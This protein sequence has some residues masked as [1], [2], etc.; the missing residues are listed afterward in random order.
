MYAK[1]GRRKFQGMIDRKRRPPIVIGVSL[2]LVLSF[3]VSATGFA[4]GSA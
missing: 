3:A 4:A 2:A 1:S